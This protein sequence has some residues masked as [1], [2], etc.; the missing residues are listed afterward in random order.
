MRLLLVSMNDDYGDPRRGR[1][2]EYNNF[3]HYLTHMQDKDKKFT[4]ITQFQ[5]Y[6]FAHKR[7]TLG[8]NGM[9]ADMWLK[10]KRFEPDVILV[11]SFDHHMNPDMHTIK[12]ATDAGIKTMHWGCDDDWRWEPYTQHLVP[13]F[14]GMVTTYWNIYRI[15]KTTGVNCFKSQW[16]ANP[17]LYYPCDEDDKTRDVVF[18][19]QPHTNRRAMIDY[20]YA[21]G[22]DVKVYGFGWQQYPR[23]SDDELPS[24]IAKAG[25]VINTSANQRGMQIKGR[26]FEVP[27][28]RTIQ[29]TDWSSHINTSDGSKSNPLDEYFQDDNSIIYW[30][31]FEELV[32]KIKHFQTQTMDAQ[33]IANRSYCDILASHTWGHRF[34]ELMTWSV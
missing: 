7:L 17:Y 16:A 22:I 28:C 14:W 3:Y 13:Y 8:P 12:K 27:A 26:H 21:N 9:A 4:G 6:D 2:F 29:L 5:H 20:L 18:F 32:D 10:I 31:T 15:A 33:V 25:M 11:I 30:Q 24:I 34:K 1:S 19:G 23:I